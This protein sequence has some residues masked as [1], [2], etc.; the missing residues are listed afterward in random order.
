[1][2]V[3]VKVGSLGFGSFGMFSPKATVFRVHVVLL[4]VAASDGAPNRVWQLILVVSLLPSVFCVQF[5][6]IQFW[7]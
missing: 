3:T 7:L 6:S 5:R 1:M 4:F 2:L